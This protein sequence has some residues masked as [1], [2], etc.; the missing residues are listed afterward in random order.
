MSDLSA[1][2]LSGIKITSETIE[3]TEKLTQRIGAKSTR[4]Y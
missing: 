3:A 2:K 1:R 4:A